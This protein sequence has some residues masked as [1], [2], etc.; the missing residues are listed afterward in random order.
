MRHCVE[1]AGSAPR[2]AAR[3][4]HPGPGGGLEAALDTAPRHRPGGIGMDTQAAQPLYTFDCGAPASPDT[5]T[6]P[7]LA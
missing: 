5:N 6:I 3:G 1:G 2:E 7:K 4:E